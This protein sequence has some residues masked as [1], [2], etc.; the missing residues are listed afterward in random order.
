MSRVPVMSLSDHYSR[1]RVS[2]RTLLTGH[3]H[4][5]WPDVA[6]EAQQQAWLDAAQ[7]VDDKWPL[8]EAQAQL[9]REG[10]ATLLGDRAA[11]VALGQ[12]THELVTRWLS[13]LPLRERPRIV[14]TDGEFHS[15][16]RQ[17]DRLAEEGLTVEKLPARPVDTL[18]ARLAGAVDDRTACVTVS[19][20]LFDTAEI[21]PG[22]ASVGAACAGVGAMLL[23][24][25]YHHLNAVPFDV[26]AL[27]LEDAFV[28][29]GGYKYCQLGEGNA[30]LR[31]PPGIRMRPVL[32]GWFA[33]FS[34]LEQA[35]QGGASGGAVR[36]GA[37]PQAFAAATYDPTSNYRAA[38][39]FAF[40]RGQGL[41]PE[42]L[43]TMSR[44]QVG[45]L[46]RRF[47]ALDLDPRRAHVEP[48]PDER[49]GGFLA[50]RTVRAHE[51]TR[52]LKRR[53]IW[54]DARGDILRVGPAPYV[55]D[56]Q[57]EDAVVAMGE[58]L[59]LPG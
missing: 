54:T 40:H 30:F 47:E 43:R 28:T 1:F 17:L 5:A 4:Q 19:S 18:A 44:R 36:Y 49:R 53:G 42:R 33:E 23:V 7:H 24:D 48:M 11:N 58:V 39:V 20:V 32:T 55:T 21:V 35:G 12:S 29:G 27:G 14:S 52:E 45:L 34:E 2:D 10:F 26:A 31:V 13:A 25:A 37:G 51:L 9:V 57:I 41:T 56:T 3:S 8:A 38:A 16:R 50:I 6:F 59:R 15:L 46:K 22:L